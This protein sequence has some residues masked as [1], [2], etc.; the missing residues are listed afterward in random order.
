MK[1]SFLFSLS[2]SLSLSF[3]ALFV[4]QLPTGSSLSPFK[5]RGRTSVPR[6][7]IGV[8]LC[9]VKDFYN[10]YMLRSLCCRAFESTA[11]CS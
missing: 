7:S 5:A 11:A 10:T 8:N 2:L 1:R 3:Q 6:E 4:C 9:Q